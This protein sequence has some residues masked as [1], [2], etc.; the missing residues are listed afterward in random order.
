MYHATPL[1][2][3]GA[4]ERPA[5]A[6]ADAYTNRESLSRD[7]REDV[8]RASAARVTLAA[9]GL[10][11]PAD[12]T[13]RLAALALDGDRAALR[14]LA[15]DAVRWART[16]HDH[17]PGISTAA[18]RRVMRQL[19]D[20]DVARGTLD[21]VTAHAMARAVRAAVGKAVLDLS[22]QVA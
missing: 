14:A 20:A 18:R 19:E 3:G 17:E 11:R 4:C 8:G 9:R 2:P 15:T 12:D 6:S 13:P 10:H 5:Y 21:C 7:D 1:E 22:R 16:Q